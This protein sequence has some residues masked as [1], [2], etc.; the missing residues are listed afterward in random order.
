MLVDILV[1]ASGILLA[2]AIYAARWGLLE[3][4]WF[5]TVWTVR[6]AVFGGLAVYLATL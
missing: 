6:L 2:A 4:L 3:L 1:I 5:V